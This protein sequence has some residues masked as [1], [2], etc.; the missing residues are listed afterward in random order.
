VQAPVDALDVTAANVA[1]ATV[2][3][4]RAKIDCAAHLNVTTDGPLKLT[5]ADCPGGGSKSFSFAG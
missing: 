2:D 3:A 4:Q 5:L 1:S